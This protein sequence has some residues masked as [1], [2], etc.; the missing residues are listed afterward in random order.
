MLVINHPERKPIPIKVWCTMSHI[1]GYYMECPSCGRMMYRMPE[2]P[3]RQKKTWTDDEE[4]VGAII[5]V[6]GREGR[7]TYMIALCRECQRTVPTFECRKEHYFQR[8]LDYMG[9]VPVN[10]EHLPSVYIRINQSNASIGP[11][12]HIGWQCISYREFSSKIRAAASI[13]ITVHKCV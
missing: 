7:Q 10:E 12:S 5:D 6:V 9:A 11:K 2:N 3:D 13:S 8:C 1:W 4:M